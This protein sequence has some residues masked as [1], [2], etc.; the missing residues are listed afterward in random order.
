MT[1][2]APRVP[3]DIGKLRAVLFVGVLAVATGRGTA[4]AGPILDQQVVQQ[5]RTNRGVGASVQFAQSFTVGIGGVLSQADV[6]ISRQ[7]SATGDLTL[8]LLGLDAGTP[9]SADVR[10][11]VT[12]A[13]ESVSLASHWFVVDLSSLNV[14]VTPG[15]RLAI[16][17]QMTGSGSGAYNWHSDAPDNTVDPYAGGGA[18][19]RTSMSAWSNTTNVSSIEN[20]MFRTYVIPSS[21][22]PD[23]GGTI[24]LA[25]LAFGLMVLAERRRRARVVSRELRAKPQAL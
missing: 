17:L 11:S 23:E 4:E 10:G 8:R 1:K 13:R 22:V 12:M 14:V 15:E 18:F 3:T 19:R 21:S 9:N 6:F 2:L 25:T 24:G 16:N 20:F 5:G 7:Q